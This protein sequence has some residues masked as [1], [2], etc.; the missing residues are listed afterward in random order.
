[1]AH[2]LRGLVRRELGEEE[3]AERDFIRANELGYNP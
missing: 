2:Y 3:G 1:M